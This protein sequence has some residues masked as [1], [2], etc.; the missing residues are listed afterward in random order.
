MLAVERVLPSV[1]EGP[2]IVLNTLKPVEMKVKGLYYG[3]WGKGKTSFVASAM[4]RFRTLWLLTATE[5]DQSR[6]SIIRAAQR[7]GMDPSKEVFIITIDSKDRMEAAINWMHQHVNEGTF[8]FDHVA[9]DGLTDLQRIYRRDILRKAPTFY[10]DR[11]KRNMEVLEEGEWGWLQNATEFTLQQLLALPV[12][13]SVTAQMMDKFGVGNLPAVQPRGFQASIG[14]F[15]NTV[16]AVVTREIPVPKDDEDM[17][18]EM[19]TVRA[20]VTSPIPGEAE[21]TKNPQGLLP[22]II[23]IGDETLADIFD[24]IA[25]GETE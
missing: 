10:R 25:G 19:R 8:P 21:V 18:P 22:P 15:F 6:P 16:A 12:H 23:E 14:G 9:L 7:L 4:K 1:G 13:V 5:E 2:A 20:L 11:H 3:L 24:M 17:E